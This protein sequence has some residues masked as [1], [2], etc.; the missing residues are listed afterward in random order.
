VRV[1]SLAELFFTLR[2]RATETSRPRAPPLP[3]KKKAPLPG[4][5]VRTPRVGEL[6]RFPQTRVAWGFM[7]YSRCRSR[8][9]LRKIRILKHPLQN[10]PRVRSGPVGRISV[11]LVRTL[12]HAVG[13]HRGSQSMRELIVADTR[14]KCQGTCSSPVGKRQ[15]VSRFHITTRAYDHIVV[16]DRTTPRTS[17]RPCDR[18]LNQPH[19]QEVRGGL[20]ARFDQKLAEEI[21]RV[22]GW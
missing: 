10:C 18:C 17:R 8:W 22:R 4:G 19:R 6:S 7:R 3:K 12:H 15:P 11:S 2:S 14:V 21:P 5:M 20:P 16:V 13:E 9:S 1:G